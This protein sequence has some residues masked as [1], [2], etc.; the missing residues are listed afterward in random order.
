[1]KRIFLLIILLTLISAC[2]LIPL[3]TTETTPPANET[4]P[5]PVAAPTD[6]NDDLQ[7]AELTPDEMADLPPAED[8]EVVEDELDDSLQ[9]DVQIETPLLA[10]G[11]PGEIPFADLT[12]DDIKRMLKEAPASL[13]SIS[14]GRTNGGSLF[15]SVPMPESPLWKINNPR[16]TWGTQETVDFVTFAIAEVNRQYPDSPPLIVGDISDPDGGPLNRHV[17]HQAG[18][19]IDLGFYYTDAATWFTPGNSGNLDLARNWA[20]V[21]TLLARTDVELILVDRNI[22]ILLY[23]YARAH[24][25]DEAFLDSVFQ[26]PNGNK[27][28]IIC[29]ARGHHTHF[30]VR[31]YNPKAQEMGRR[32]YG[33]LLAMNK[34]KPPTYYVYHKVK[35]GQT[36]GH[37][38]RR[39]GTSVAAIKSAN[40]LRSNLI[41]AGKSYRIPRRGGVRPTPAP[42]VVP[43][44]HVPP[45]AV[46]VARNEDEPR[47]K[48]VPEEH[49]SLAV[50][51]ANVTGAV[52][53]P[54]KPATVKPAP[55]K[56]K[57]QAYT[58]RVRYTVR[59][60][61]NLWS[62]A[63]RHGVHVKDIKRWNGLRSERLKPG[64]RLTLY[65]KSAA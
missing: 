58:K 40:G 49:M 24:G 37:L 63:R 61:D 59:S 20:L 33:A 52:T 15:N 17:S 3:R 35:R 29:H 42:V 4:T 12:D 27:R 25:E 45:D 28:R 30:H 31:F 64:Q 8:E 26:Y 6:E 46:M 43:P 1:M 53:A 50:K 2:S 19:D 41:R 44:R 36:L 34:I 9:E 55:V 32:A 22:Q 23:N 14:M 62:I 56:V 39:Y 47:A 18:R 57:K 21:R 48:N 10:E 16:E 54:T 13:G 60:G 11:K 65:V 7:E 5:P 51:P 38:A